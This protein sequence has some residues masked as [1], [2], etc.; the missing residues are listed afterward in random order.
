MSY[1]RNDSGL[2]YKW[3]MIE[4]YDRNDGSLYYKWVTIVI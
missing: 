2:H 4:I 1:D 3:V